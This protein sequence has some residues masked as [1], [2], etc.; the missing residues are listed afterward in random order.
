MAVYLNSALG[1]SVRLLLFAAAAVYAGLVLM[2]YSTDGPRYR[3]RLRLADPLR[4]FERLLVWLGVKA[5]VVLIAA[6]RTALATLSEASAEV[7]EWV[8]DHRSQQDPAS[9]RSRFL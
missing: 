7:G 6:F 8:M 5:I 9:F 3:P 2:T 1:W 4:S